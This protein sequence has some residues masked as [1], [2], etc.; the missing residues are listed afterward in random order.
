MCV[1]FSQTDLI[2]G[3]TLH[4]GTSI[5]GFLGQIYMISPF[6]LNLWLLVY[7]NKP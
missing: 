6:G 3:A 4:T 1:F 7:R 2:L 5:P